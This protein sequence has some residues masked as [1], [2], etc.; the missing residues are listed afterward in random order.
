MPEGAEDRSE[1]NDRKVGDSLIRLEAK[2]D[3]VL[4][5]HEARIEDL[6]R[7][8]GETS[9]TLREYDSRITA[10]ALTI[11]E[12]RG[13]DAP[14]APLFA[15]LTTEIHYIAALAGSLLPGGR[16]DPPLLMALVISSLNWRVFNVQHERFHVSG[17]RF[18]GG[19][20]LPCP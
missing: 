3:V 14:V 4:G 10:N 13:Q 6:V 18:I 2:I 5:R 8:Q 15:C 12:T 7:R 9:S 16:L 20:L 19:Y 17:W 11:A 1:R